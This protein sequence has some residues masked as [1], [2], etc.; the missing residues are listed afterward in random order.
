MNDGKCLERSANQRGG[1]PV[2]LP[3]L[4]S[5][6]N[7]WGRHTGLPLRYTRLQAA[8]GALVLLAV[9]VGVSWLVWSQPAQT[10][11]TAK[12]P[13]ILFLFSDDQRADTIHALGNPRIHT[14][15]LDR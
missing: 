6:H 7:H 15:N 2:C 13:N 12:A 8:S 1:R 10:G 14:P 9:L 4:G 5:A 11:A 3:W